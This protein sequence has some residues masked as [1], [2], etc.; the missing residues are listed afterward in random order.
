MTAL[1][2]LVKV[3]GVFALLAGVLWML[4]RTDGLGGRTRGRLLEVRGTTKLGKGAA[5]TMVRVEGQDLLLGVTDH[6]VTLLSSATPDL[7]P[8]PA[9]APATAATTAKSLPEL[10]DHM[11]TTRADLPADEVAA[12]LTALRSGSTPRATDGSVATSRRATDRP[13]PRTDARR[14][15]EHP[16]IRA[17]R[18]ALNA[19][20]ERDAVS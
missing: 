4:K 1:F 9:L 18:H 5:L 8:E 11:L 14:F 13:S 7:H 6:A 2:L 16:W 19:S 10:L 17:L 12:T 15:Q 3:A 20:K